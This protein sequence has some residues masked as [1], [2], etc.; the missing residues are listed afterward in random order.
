[1]EYDLKK[2][3]S[4]HCFLD[5]VHKFVAEVPIQ[6]KEWQ[7]YREDALWAMRIVKKILTAAPQS[8]PCKGKPIQ[9][10]VRVDTAKKT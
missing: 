8:Y 1:M 10:I 6:D 5:I 2:L 3:P 4:V 9:R 7:T